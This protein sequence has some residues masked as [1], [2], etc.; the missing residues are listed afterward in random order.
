MCNL[1]AFDIIKPLNLDIYAE[2]LN[3]HLYRH[4]HCLRERGKDD[5]SLEPT[6]R[7]SEFLDRWFMLSIFY[8]W[9]Y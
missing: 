6:F 5:S 1:Q 7:Y 8:S 9:K 3:F 4:C 2:Q